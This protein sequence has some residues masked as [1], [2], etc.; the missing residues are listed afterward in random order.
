MKRESLIA[1]KLQ[2]YLKGNKDDCDFDSDEKS[3]IGLWNCTISCF[4]A[5]P[6]FQKCLKDR[7]FVYVGVEQKQK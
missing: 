2:P 6:C 5:S 7:N 4:E 1:T 3:V